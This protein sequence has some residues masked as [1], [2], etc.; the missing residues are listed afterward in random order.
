M[1]WDST[2]ILVLIGAVISA[3]AS[4]NVNGTFNRFKSVTNA[5]RITAEHAAEQ[6]LRRAGIFDVRIERIR[7]RKCRQM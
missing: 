4:S 7:E 3:I 6:I 1:Y 5:R 2:Y